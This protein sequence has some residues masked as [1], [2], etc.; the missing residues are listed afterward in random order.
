MYL[1][2]PAVI[3]RFPIIILS[4]LSLLLLTGCGGG[5]GT[6]DPPDTTKPVI[7]LHGP[8]PQIIPLGGTYTE[9]G[10][11]AYD[12]RDGNI[13]AKIRID[14]SAVNTAAEGNYT[15]TYDVSDAAG[16]AADT[17]RR[18][19]SVIAPPN[20]APT[21]DAG[22]DQTVTEGEP[23]TLDASK[24]T[25]SDGRIVSYRWTEGNTTLSTKSRFT[26]SDFTVG[27][28]TVTLTVTDDDGAMD[29][30]TVVVKVTTAP[31][32]T[33]PVITLH[34]PNPQIIPLG[35]TYTELGAEAYDNRDGNITA[36]IRID[37]SAV[38]TSA[39]GNY[40]VTYDVSDAAGNAADEVIRTVNVVQKA[41]TVLPAFPEAEG[42]GAISK[43][44]RGG[45][46]IEVTN[47]ND[48][49]KG[50]LRA[51]IEA[52][53]SRI[54]IFRVSGYIDLKKPIRLT[55][56]NITIAG[57]TAPGDGICLRMKPGNPKGIQGLIYVP[58]SADG[59]HDVVIRYLKFRQG[60]SLSY[61]G[62]PN[63]KLRTRPLNIYFREGHNVIIDHV[64]S[65]WTRDNLLTISLSS[66]ARESDAM[67]NFS[68]QNS[69]FGESE[70]GHSTGM[71]IQGGSA[72]TCS[73]TGKWVKNISIHR[74]LF[75]GSDHRNPRVSTNGVKVINNVIYNWGNRAGSTTRDVVVDFIN[76]Y[77]KAGP[78]TT[79]DITYQRVWHE[80]W[81][82][83]CTNVSDGSIYMSGNIMIPHYNPPSNP[84][85]FYL[86]RTEDEN[87]KLVNL[88]DR[89]KR[90]DALKQAMFPVKI[91]NIQDTYNVVLADVGCNARLNE[92]GEFVSNIDD[93]DLRMINNV[94]DS[95]GFDHAVNEEDWENG[96]VSFPAMSPG[97]LYADS[98]GD[99]MADVWEY[100]KFGNLSV[101]Q[102]DDNNKTDYD[103]DGYYDLDE[104]LNGS[105]PLV[106]YIN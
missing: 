24:S 74:N 80:P 90:F 86:E 18:T 95:T 79:D 41:I 4:I 50:S 39:E 37:A 104:F 8:N 82:K 26:K 16:N 48:S 40:T 56:S 101:A 66:Q 21:A 99:G 9:L 38:N 12:D 63:D 11:E 36:K 65:Q 14:A 100:M 53:G 93:V 17:V 98:D 85:A 83:S 62:N 103:G 91:L 35:G 31:D 47:T 84:Y 60:W 51:A 77:Y 106:P 75:T 46:I 92:K 105:D 7:T 94:K 5:S 96:N 102:Y 70:E 15:V 10:A 67:Y 25:D 3:K 78:M 28:H 72:T 19:V 69:L 45:R 61:K 30:D 13:T 49:G 27:T 32:T 52:N 97:T 57:Q 59:L 71:N 33:K 42:F 58:N 6:G 87:S 89:Y 23:V 22:E 73:Y 20:R 44:G 55:N 54:V 68:V 34:G 76:N 88:S 2:I 64:S 1:H 29:S 81:K 43:G